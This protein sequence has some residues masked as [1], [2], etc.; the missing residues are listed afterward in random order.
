M[1][2]TSRLFN[3]IIYNN[4]TE[5]VLWSIVIDMS[6]LTIFIFQHSIMTNDF[7]KHI[8]LKLDVEHLNRSIYNACSSVTLHL[9]I[10]KWQ[11]TPTMMLWKIE[12]SNDIIWMLF[13]GFHVFGW[14]IIYSGCIMMDIAELCGLKQIWYKV[15]ARSSPLDAKSNELCRY[16]Q[17]M[18]HPS[19]TGFLI[20]LWIYPFMSMDRLLLATILTIYM[21][22]MWTIDSDDYNYHIRYFRRKQIELSS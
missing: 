14:S 18:R 5:S 10:N 8:F 12:T 2:N 17:H 15:S 7:V 3:T 1:V 4:A 6:L 11:Q 16:M 20:I 22:L 9:L 13:S 19:L 21:M